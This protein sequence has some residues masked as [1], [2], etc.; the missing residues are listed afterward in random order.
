MIRHMLS[1][2]G[3]VALAGGLTTGCG[4]SAT[5]PAGHAVAAS[6]EASD[7][8]IVL[9]AGPGARSLVIEHLTP[10]CRI[11]LARALVRET[12]ATVAI[13]ILQ[14]VATPAHRNGCLQDA[15]SP[16]LTVRLRSPIGGRR[17][18]GEG[19]P[20]PLGL[21]SVAYLTRSMADPPHPAIALPLVP[22]VVG[23]ATPEA[24]EVL[25]REGF[26]IDVV[27]DEHGVVLR[28]SPTRA[29][30]APGSHASSPY[31][32]TVTITARA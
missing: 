14:R 22:N 2:V 8:W 32:G 26:R 29:H 10:T 24:I 27:G 18:L 1:A 12:R 30:S 21:G 3:V 5:A 23:L 19:L 6:R 16:R 9:E 31:T 11:G 15:V 20:R 25:A 4:G 17:I 28:Q 13:R 7:D